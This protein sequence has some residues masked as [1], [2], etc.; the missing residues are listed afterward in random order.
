MGKELNRKVWLAGFALL[1]PMFLLQSCKPDEGFGGDASVKGEIKHHDAPIPNA[2][3]YIKFG[4]IEFPGEDTG[5]YDHAVQAGANAE[6]SIENLQKGKYYLYSVGFDTAINEAV[7]G[8]IPI[9]IDKKK[10]VVTINI[11]VTEGD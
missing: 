6:Y 1:I 8:G 3:V 11:P 7:Q 5:L 4:S 9:S 2:F 10:D